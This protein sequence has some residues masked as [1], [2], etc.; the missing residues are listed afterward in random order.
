MISS[1]SFSSCQ[2]LDSATPFA[3][4]HFSAGAIF[5]DFHA[6]Y[7]HFHFTAFTLIFRFRR[8]AA[9]KPFISG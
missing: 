2:V 8:A 9:R 7:F 4:F 6:D 1:S 5:A 3:F